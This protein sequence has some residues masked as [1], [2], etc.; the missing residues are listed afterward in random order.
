MYIRFYAYIVGTR[1]CFNRAFQQS[2]RELGM[3]EIDAS[4]CLDADTLAWV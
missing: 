4:Y 2:E 1:R 3:R